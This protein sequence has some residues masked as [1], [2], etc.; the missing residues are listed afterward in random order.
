MEPVQVI[1]P[2]LNE[3][4]AL[5]SVLTG[6]PA[7]FRPLVVDNG[8]TDGTAELA[9]RLGAEVVDC[10]ERGY[11]AACHA[12]LL[13]AVAP[14]I[15][16][17]DADGSLAGADLPRLVAPIHRGTADLVIG[18]RRPVSRRAWPWR[19]RFA[20]RQLARQ[21]SGRTGI[22]INDLGPMRAMRREALL[23]LRLRDRRSGYP[24]ETLIG[25]ADAGWRIDQIEIDYA[26]RIGRSKITGTPWGAAR[27]VRDLRAAI[28]S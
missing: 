27:A 14:V 4:A 9:R 22:K 7:G 24:A 13:A 26:P 23:E 2:C 5:P 12:G 1:L 17:M 16:V 18:T 3:A 25:A 28:R 21:L 19:L 15:A 11:G 10:V 8:S 6:L 20:N